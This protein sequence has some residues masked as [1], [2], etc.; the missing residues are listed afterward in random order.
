MKTLIT[1]SFLGCFH[2]YVCVCMGEGEEQVRQREERREGGEDKGWKEIEEGEWK[3]GDGKG[4]RDQR[5]EKEGRRTRGEDGERRRRWRRRG[6]G[7][8]GGEEEE[9]VEEEQVEEEQEGEE[10]VRGAS[11]VNSETTK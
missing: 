2:S 4:E 3:R 11:K 10:E 8:G 5:R 7:G 6:G 1:E 9:E